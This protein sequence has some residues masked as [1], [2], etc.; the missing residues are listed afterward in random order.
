ML[1][2]LDSASSVYGGQIEKLG[3]HGQIEKSPLIYTINTSMDEILEGAP[4]E[5]VI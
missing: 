2:F 4:L 3:Y 5:E 1:W